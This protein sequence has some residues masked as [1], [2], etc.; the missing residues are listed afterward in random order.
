MMS[1]PESRKMHSVL[2]AIGQ[3]VMEKGNRVATTPDHRTGPTHAMGTLS[4]LLVV[5]AVSS[6]QVSAATIGYWRFEDSPGFTADSSGNGFTLATN[7]TAPTQITKPAAFPTPVPGN[8]LP[9]AE[10]ASFGG[11]GHFTAADNALF[12]V[13]SQ[14]TIE[15]FISSSDYSTTA[16][17]ILAAQYAASSNN[18]AWH[19]S[20]TTGGVLRLGLSS[21][22]TGATEVT[23]LS[24]YT[25]DDGDDYYVAAVFDG[26]LAEANRITFYI[27]NLTDNG[28]ILSQAASS[29]ISSVFDSITSFTIGGAVDMSAGGGNRN[30]RFTGAMDEVRWSNSALTQSQLLI[31]PEPASLALLIAGG[32]LLLPSRRRIAVSPE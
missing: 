24:P 9:N 32:T 6:I 21:G 3:F 1:I 10:S 28:P 4:F 20:L 13:G 26:T 14:F 12:S 27:K 23:T 22:G 11:A 8:G 2:L 18:R 30:D 29:A 5:V 16:A 17:Q 15:A 7:G 25:L 31:I 19:F